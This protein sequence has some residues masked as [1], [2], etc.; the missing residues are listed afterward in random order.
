MIYVSNCKRL[1]PQVFWLF[2]VPFDLLLSDLCRQVGYELYAMDT[3]V[4]AYLLERM[5]EEEGLGKQ[6]MQEVAKSLISYIKYLA[7]TNPYISP[8]ELQMQQWGAM[9]YLEDKK[10]QVFQE[11]KKAFQTCVREAELAKLTQITQELSPQLSNYPSLIQFAE[12]VRDLLLDF[13][14]GL[15]EF[16]L[17]TT[18]PN[19]TQ[20][21]QDLEI[22]LAKFPKLRIK[23]SVR[24]NQILLSDPSQVRFL[25]E[26]L[27]RAGIE[28]AV[29]GDWG[30]QTKAALRTFQQHR[31]L[32]LDGI[33]DS[34]T[35]Q[36]LGLELRDGKLEPFKPGKHYAIAIGINQY[37]AS[38]L[39][40]AQYAVRDALIMQQWFS[41]RGFERVHRLTD[42]SAPNISESPS[43]PIHAQWQQFWQANFSQAGL[44]AEDTLWFYFSG[45]SVGRRGRDYLLLADSDLDNLEE[46]ALP[47]TKLVRQLH[48]S[49]AGRV[50]LLLDADHSFSSDEVSS[51]EQQLSQELSSERGLIILYAS[52]P[53]QGAYEI[54]ALQQGTFTYALR[55]ALLST[56]GNLSLERLEQF[57]RERV[58]ELN[59]Q[60]DRPTQTPQSF[61]FPTNLQKWI[62]FPSNLQVF[63]FKT[64]T[65]NRRGEIIQQDTKLAQYYTE[66]LGN[67]ILLEMVAIPGGNFMMGSLEGEG[68][69]SEKPQHKVTVPPFFM[70]KYPVTQAQ[71]R[72][73]ASRTDLKVERDLAPHP[74]YF[75]VQSDR[76]IRPVE[77][78]SW[79]DAVEFCARL[80]N[81]T[82]K[83][84]RLPSEAQ[85]EYACRAGTTTPF[86]FGETITSD[87]ANYNGEYTYA[88]E[89]PDYCRSAYRLNGLWRDVIDDDI[90]FRVV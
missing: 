88:D 70:G 1:K 24:L 45:Y 47:I 76:E 79:Y 55:E 57:L 40:P 71:W 12:S 69:S 6:R 42:V 52:S 22:D 13:K 18:R 38:T 25:Q 90:G 5:E 30:A 7:Q 77:Q 51:L 67:G 3:A 36:E 64:P 86:Y 54:D 14:P 4:R 17:P 11:I 63:E 83:E 34:Q 48:S 56:Q 19:I 16:E 58:T 84:Y 8:A 74:A 60:Y 28:I 61:I 39:P 21:S 81:L 44:S 15:T 73:I 78:I 62:P 75:N 89:Y 53:K 68:N 66:D 72:A 50:I 85:W 9:V 29:D 82:G 37:S 65:V 46:T 49:G 31:G 32:T 87:L 33:L 26:A 27:K 80:S 35:L 41:H 20:L 43:P 2:L 23:E 59:D 10:E